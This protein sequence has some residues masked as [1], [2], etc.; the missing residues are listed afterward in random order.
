MG[1]NVTGLNA[2]LDHEIEL[3]RQGPVCQWL[4]APATIDDEG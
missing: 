2:D 3:E 4:R 1:E